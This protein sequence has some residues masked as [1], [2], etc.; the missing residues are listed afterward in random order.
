MPQEYPKDPEAVSQP[1]PEQYH[2]VEREG[3]G[4]FSRVCGTRAG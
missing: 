3:H 4:E 1:S 2:D